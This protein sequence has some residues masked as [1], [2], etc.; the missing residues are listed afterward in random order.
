MSKQ[1]HYKTETELTERIDDA[2][3]EI[4]WAN[5]E[6][7]I[8]N[9]FADILREYPSRHSQRFEYRDRAARLTKRANRIQDKTLKKLKRALAEIQTGIL[10]GVEHDGSVAVDE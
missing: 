10:P 7:E 6:A 9:R 5:E 3:R 4:K 1:E 8:L 2:H